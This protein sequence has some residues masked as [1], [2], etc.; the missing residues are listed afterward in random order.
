MRR[1]ATSVPNSGSPSSTLHGPDKLKTS[2]TRVATFRA[3]PEA[4]AMEQRGQ[5]D[6]I[7]VL[8]RSELL[9]DVRDVVPR[10]QGAVPIRQPAVGFAPCTR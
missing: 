1:T 6:V 9:F 3:R 7:T 8:P 10:D 4:S 2:N 5:D